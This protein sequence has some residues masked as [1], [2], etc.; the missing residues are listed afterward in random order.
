MVWDGR[1]ATCLQAKIVLNALSPAPMEVPD[2]EALCIDSFHNHETITKVA[3]GAVRIA[4][5]VAN[6]D[7]TPTYRREMAGI[8]TEKA[9]N[10]LVARE[11]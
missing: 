9:L 5:P 8:L 1:K 11:R 3:E 2:A 7:S 4:H 6:T 10:A